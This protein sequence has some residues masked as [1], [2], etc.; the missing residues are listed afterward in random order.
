M[1]RCM[2]ESGPRRSGSGSTPLRRLQPLGTAGSAS[3]V[4]KP[5]PWFGLRIS[6]TCAGPDFAFPQT[7]GRLP[8]DLDRMLA[9]NHGVL[10][11]AADDPAVHKLV[12]EVQ[13]LLRTRSV[14]Q[15]PG[16]VERVGAMVNAGSTYSR[17]EE[18]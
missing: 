8:D 9:F 15:D 3:E 1:V 10:R 17:R 5:R 12:T 6:R 14:L 4:S 7:E 2:T 16:L 18:Q 13:H 11:L